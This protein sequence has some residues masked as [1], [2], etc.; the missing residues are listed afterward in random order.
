[1][2][3]P[4]D[5]ILVFDDLSAQ[6]EKHTPAAQELL[7][8]QILDIARRATDKIFVISP[9]HTSELLK[10]SRL[11]SSR[12][13]LIPGE[14]LEFHVAKYSKLKDIEWLVEWHWRGYVESGQVTFQTNVWS[15][16]T[17]VSV[18]DLI[19]VYSDLRPVNYRTLE[20]LQLSEPTKSLSVLNAVIEKAQ[21]SARGPVPCVTYCQSVD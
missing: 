21:A 18:L 14:I 10:D 6:L 11:G 1:M 20:G 3:E 4:D 5:T 8:R 7:W 13:D 16:R 17:L 9:E 15:E 2:Q 19:P 12:S